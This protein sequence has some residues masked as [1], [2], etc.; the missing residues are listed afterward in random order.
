[1][2]S[3]HEGIAGPMRILFV[4]AQNPGSHS[5][6]VYK[7]L[8]R[9]NH[10]VQSV[11]PRHFIPTVKSSVILRIFRRV[12]ARFFEREFNL[13]VLR[14]LQSFNPELLIV[15]KGESVFPSTVA[16]AKSKGIYCVNIFPDVSI[17]THG[18]W[19]PKSLPLYDHHF[20]TKSFGPEDLKRHLG[21]SSVTVLH[22]GFD[23][24]IHR[25]IPLGAVIPVELRCDISFIGTWSPKKEALLDV[26]INK[27]PDLTVKI[28]GS[29]WE[30]AESKAVKKCAIGK[31]IMGRV[32][33][34]AIQGSVINLAILSESRVG[35][36]AGD[37]VTS[38]TFDIPASGGFMLHERTDE[39]LDSFAEGTDIVCF[40]TADELVSQIK[41][42]MFNDEEREGIRL[43]G[44][45]ASV[46]KYSIDFRVAEI[47]KHCAE[48]IRLTGERCV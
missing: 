37:Q 1:M 10:L 28:W 9:A 5:G 12:L 43:R 31:D 15:Y 39:L 24:E 4:G 20:T 2:N 21:I 3:V 17:F 6:G 34:I 47:L 29:Q 16:Y 22:H 27:F 41:H 42:Y 18:P 23:P 44:H 19:L 25:P 8:V 40:S 14:D 13:Q 46:S 35:S 45:H 38:R 33:A 48:I 26:V 7:A 11:D 30:R 32:Y 36:S